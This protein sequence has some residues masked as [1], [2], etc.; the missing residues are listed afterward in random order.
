MSKY[1]ENPIDLDIIKPPKEEKQ[2]I[3]VEERL[4][5]KSNE[6]EED[7]KNDYDSV[8]ETYYELVVKGKDAL[9]GLLDVA[10]QSES[11]R[12]YEVVAETIR[13]IA[14]TNE[15]IID[16]HKKAVDIEKKKTEIEN[17]KG[18][19]VTNNNTVFVGNMKEFQ[20]MLKDMKRGKDVEVVTQKEG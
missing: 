16:L 12:A 19:N 15:K 5:E 4:P 6:R 9:D 7:M 18:D 11:A 20:L 1:D 2:I 13:T 8:R 17:E 14:D 3:P 10:S